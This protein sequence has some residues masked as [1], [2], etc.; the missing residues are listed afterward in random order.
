MEKL[1]SALRAI[2]LGLVAL[3]LV[4]VVVHLWIK[5]VTNPNDTALFEIS[6][7]YSDSM[8]IQGELSVR[9]R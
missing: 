1:T 7:D 5:M 3:A 9:S 8:S 6:N 4:P 2:V